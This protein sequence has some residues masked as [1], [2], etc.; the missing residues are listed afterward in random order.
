[1]L[2]HRVAH[3]SV[4]ILGRI[5]GTAEFGRIDRHPENETVPGVLACR[6][7][8]DLLYFNEESVL[9]EILDH[10][11]AGDP[12]IELVVFDLSTTNH[13]DLAGARMVRRLHQELSSRKIELKLVGARGNVRDLL[14]LDGLEALVGR[15]DRRLSLDTIMNQEKGEPEEPQVLGH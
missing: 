8:G 2:V 1:M 5:A 11:S 13:V 6:V 4:S 3:P 12:P 14:R 9:E 15:I 10:V 7:E